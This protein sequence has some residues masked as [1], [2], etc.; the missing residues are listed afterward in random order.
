MVIGETSTENRP[1]NRCSRV[2]AAFLHPLNAVLSRT[3]VQMPHCG[4]A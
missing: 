3:T 1:V 2:M 4:D